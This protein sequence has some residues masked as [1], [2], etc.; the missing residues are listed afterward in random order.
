M[1]GASGSRANKYGVLQFAQRC[2]VP[3]SERTAFQRTPQPAPMLW[4]ILPDPP[5]C[6]CAV[7]DGG[8]TVLTMR[9]QTNLDL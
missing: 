6:R 3:K 4:P 7:C 1:M 9:V 5:D 8:D 2:H